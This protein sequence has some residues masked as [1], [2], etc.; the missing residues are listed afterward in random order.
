MQPLRNMVVHCGYTE[1]T[2]VAFYILSVS[3]YVA[4]L[5]SWLGT[6][7]YYVFMF[8]S[9]QETNS[10][11]FLSSPLLLSVSLLS[12]QQ[13]FLRT[14]CSSVMTVTVAITCIA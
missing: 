3:L 6:A 8:S 7:S 9:W 1:V 5:C 14:S 11:H 10:H 2:P 13:P 12:S 4:A